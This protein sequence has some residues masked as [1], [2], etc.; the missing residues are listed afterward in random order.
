MRLLLLIAISGI[1]FSCSKGL[2]PLRTWELAE[3]SVGNKKI[4]FSFKAPLRDPS[5]GYWDYQ[6]GIVLPKEASF[7]LVGEAKILTGS[8]ELKSS[9]RFDSA[10]KSS[11][12]GD[13]TRISHL[14]AGK[15]GVD[16][17]KEYRVELTFERP[18]VSETAVVLHFLSHT[19]SP[20][21]LI[22]VANNSAQTDG[23]KSPN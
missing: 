22:K 19:N 15:L 12:L 16:D 3:A 17:G 9:F 2:P 7:D 10:T 1:L 21:Q 23:D 13:K 4:E 5:K 14:L 8:G 20:P 6:L 11:W 18:L